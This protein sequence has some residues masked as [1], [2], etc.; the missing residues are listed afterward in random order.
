[1]NGPTQLPVIRPA[2]TAGIKGWRSHVSPRLK[3]IQIAEGASN[4]FKLHAASHRRNAGREGSSA[5]RQVKTQVALTSA[6]L[7]IIKETKVYSASLIVRGS[8][9]PLC[10]SCDYTVKEA[11][12]SLALHASSYRSVL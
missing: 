9:S 12:A 5:N 10:A 3:R 6:M 8:S 11:H 1:M 2:C 7:I 4:P